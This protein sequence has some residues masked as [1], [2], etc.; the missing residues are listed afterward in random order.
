MPLYLTED[1]VGQVLTMDIAIEAVEEG[2][3]QFAIGEAV[4][5]PRA[6]V[7]AGGGA[8]HFMAAS[9]SGLGVMGTKT[10]G[11]V[12]GGGGDIRFYVQL[13]SIA[14]GE[15][16]AFI[17]ASALGQ[18]R[19]GAAS[20]VA[21]R[22]MARDNAS[23]VGVIGS[24]YQAATQL[25]AVSR[26]REI[27]SAKVFS[28]TAARRDEFAKAMTS[29]LG[30]DVTPVDSG[31]G[32]V[33][34]ADVVITI[35]SSSRP[36]LLG[37]WLSPGT[38]I[39]AAGS[40]HWMRRELDDEAVYRSGLI[41][42]DDVDQAKTECGELIHAIERGVKRWQQV[43]HLADVVSGTIPGRD[44]ED[45]ITLFESQGIALEDIAAGLRVYELA[46]EK[47]LGIELPG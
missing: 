46:R 40:N 4:N 3:R 23:T 15:P 6:R 20:G 30:I 41:A 9:S 26:V 16:L 17:E 7:E 27:A 34:G 37:K 19:T 12:R 21:T 22:Y 35:T 31:E 25:E 8:L 43:R 47:G 11:A 28:R 14:T 39:N 2:F 36:V 32:C 42:T 24:G 45:Q 38:H 29:K 18:I 13:I 1:D 44:G 10:Y 33:E 5:H